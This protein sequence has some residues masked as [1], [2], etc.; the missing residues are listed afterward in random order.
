[1]MRFNAILFNIV[2][3]CNIRCRHCGYADSVRRGEVSHHD[4]V[5]WV[6]Q[7]V[8][9]RIPQIIF[10]GGEPFMRFELLRAGVEAV[11]DC[12][13]SSGVF[14]N[15]LWGTT[16]DDCRKVLSQLPRLTHLYLS[17]DRYHLEYVPAKNLL[18]IIEASQDFGVESIV[19]CITYT[20]EADRHHIAGLFDEVRQ[21][22]QFHYARVIGSEYVQDLVPD[23]CESGHEFVPD[24]FGTECFLHTPLINPTGTVTSC[25]I[26]KL[27]THVDLE[28][29][30][31]YLGSLREH[32]LREIFD[33][34]ESNCL[35]Q[36]L[37]VHGPRAVVESALSSSD[38]EDLRTRR[39]AS[40]CEMCVSALSRPAVA[41]ELQ[42]R[43]SQRAAQSHTFLRRLVVLG[44]EV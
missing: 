34:N 30:P 25:H 21:V 3:A 38:N 32:S 36:Y 15:S 10:T 31:Y 22:V 8:E 9:Y 37:R 1:M 12:D 2:E 44:D 14:T 29:S 35:Y 17:C 16:V 26:G 6:R 43:A 24:N 7:A 11:A 18:N 39:F 4:L 5:Q 33:R 19:V 23:V 28:A 41:A 40:D 27:E 13:G 20:S 42:A